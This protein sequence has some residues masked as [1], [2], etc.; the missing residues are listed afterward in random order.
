MKVTVFGATGAVG[1][2]LVHALLAKGDTVTAYVR[3]EAKI[4][5]AWNGTVRV[6]VGE[7]TDAEAIDKAITGADAVASALGPSMDRKATGLPLAEGNRLI[8]AAMDRHGVR[9]YVGNGTPTVLDQRDRRTFQPRFSALMARTFLHR[10][11]DEIVQMSKAITTSDLD[12]TIVRFMAPRNG[13]ARGVRRIG[14]FGHTKIG[15]AV[16]RAD[17]G[18]FTADQV[19]DNN[20]LKAAPAISN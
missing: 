2:H 14:F 20:Y 16:T 17:I 19:H 1:Q 7:I 12:W 8:V 15:F 13:S 5:A 11:Y 18:Q 9:R 10:A 4:P 3:N 6:V